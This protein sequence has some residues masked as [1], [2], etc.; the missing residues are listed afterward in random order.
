MLAHEVTR[1]VVTRKGFLQL[2]VSSV[3]LSALG[4]SA[5]G[6]DE[7]SGGAGGTA[8]TS[9]GTT[10]SSTTGSKSSSAANSSSSSSSSGTTTAATTTGGTT[11]ATTSGMMMLTCGS[12]IG[13]NH[14][15]VLDVTVADVEAGTE[16]IY[17]ITGSNGT[18]GH[19]VTVTAA[20]FTT[21]AGG[22]TVMKPSSPG[23]GHTHMV[24]I[25][26]TLE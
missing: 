15:H 7:G 25:T 17:D 13:S 16:K 9:N 6:D 22:G 11:A 3:G 14:M 1:M 12:Q 21:L 20:E 10:G 18:H 24:T 26:C 4:M 2:V 19:S 23:G 5:C 8:T